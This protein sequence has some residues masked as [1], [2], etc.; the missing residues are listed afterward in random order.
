MALRESF[1]SLAQRLVALGD[2]AEVEVDLLL[3][4]YSVTMIQVNVCSC[5]SSNEATAKEIE[6][7][8]KRQVRN[9][10]ETWAPWG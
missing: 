7:N 9:M 4:Q 8:N 5:I 1:A 2:G 6:N 3:S 10:E